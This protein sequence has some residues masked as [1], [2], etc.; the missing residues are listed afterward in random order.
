[1][2]RLLVLFLFLSQVPA[3]ATFTVGANKQ[4]CSSFSSGTTCVAAITSTT[5]RLLV[6]GSITN[7]NT[8]TLSVSDTVNGA[9]TAISTVKRGTGTSATYSWQMFYVI[10][11]G[12]GS[13]T[14]TFTTTG[15]NAL[16]A[17]SEGDFSFTGGTVVIDATPTGSINQSVTASAGV[18]TLS[19][20]SAVNTGDL[21]IAACLYI[22]S[23]CTL[24]SGFTSDDGGFAGATGGLVEYKIGPSTG[25]QTATFGAGTTDNLGGSLVAFTDAALSSGVAQFPRIE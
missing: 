11:T 7:D 4:G 22:D 19:G 9:W 10:A 14:V 16:H 18:A 25:A 15:T 6:L 21:L 23:T 5:G 24:G 2:K 20:V 8:S 3:F 1:M 12:T 13:A 17:W